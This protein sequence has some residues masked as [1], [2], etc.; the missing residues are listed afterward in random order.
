MV[1]DVKIWRKNLSAGA[2][3]SPAALPAAVAAE[4]AGL[5]SGYFRVVYAA[6]GEVLLRVP[7][8]APAATAVLVEGLPAAVAAP[9]LD[10]VRA[11][12]RQRTASAAACA[13]QSARR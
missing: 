13:G 4:A 11:Y 6:F 7:L 10:E 12:R 9:A 2:A 8:A 3:P 5:L 1:V